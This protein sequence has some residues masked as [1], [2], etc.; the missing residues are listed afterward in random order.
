MKMSLLD[1]VQD[2]MA[3]MESDNIQSI[4]DTEE[5]E[6]V[7]RIVRESF[8]DL[9]A[10]REWPFLHALT[11]LT[12]YSD[13]NNPTK[14]Y[15]GDTVNRVLWLKYNAEDVT[16]MEPRDYYE[17]IKARDTSLSN[18]DA[19]GYITDRDPLYWTTYDDLTV[20]MDSYDSAVDSTLQQSKLDA[21]CVVVPSWTHEDSFI[22]EMPEKMFATL[23]ASAKAVAFSQV[24]QM[25]NPIQQ[26]RASQGFSRL[27]S[28]A[29]KATSDW[30]TNGV[31]YGRK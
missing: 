23:L 2:I 30:N 19:N 8:F 1:M 9:M 4:D 24:K 16:Y 11:S 25:Q 15:L 10:K 27:Q 18:V 7:A 26:Q 22:P 21:Y 5:S 13:V 3:S 14:F 20:E 6:I 31:N 28:E 12:P 17:M 29:R